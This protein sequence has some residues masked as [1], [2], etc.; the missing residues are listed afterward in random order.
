V[1]RDRHVFVHGRSNPLLGWCNVD[2][3]PHADPDIHFNP[4]SYTD[5]HGN[6]RLYPHTHTNHNINPGS[7]DD[8]ANKNSNNNANTSSIAGACRDG[9]G[10]D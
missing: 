7:S 1:Q 10:R 3:S 8:N 5:A 4:D 9:F 2:G 6:P